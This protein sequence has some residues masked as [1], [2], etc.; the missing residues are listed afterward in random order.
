MLAIRVKQVF[1]GCK[2]AAGAGVVFVDDGR[3][4]GVESTTAD[5]PPGCRV[6][7]R[8]TA[9]VLPG[10]VDA[11]V[12]LLADSGPGALDRL[13]DH[14]DDD[15]DRVIEQTLRVT[16]SSGVTTV[17]DLGDRNYAV[18]EW[19]TQHAR[20]MAPTIVASGPP[21]T[22][23]R[24]HCATCLQDT[25]DTRPAHRSFE[26]T[27]DRTPP[28]VRLRRCDNP[29]SRKGIIMNHKSRISTILA[30][31]GLL[32]T[33]ALGVT[34]GVASAATPGYTYE[35][36]NL[37]SQNCIDVAY[38]SINDGARIQQW[39][40]YHGRPERWR[41]DY[42]ESTY[43][44]YSYLNNGN[45][46]RVD[47]FNVVNDYSGR[48]LDLPYN[49]AYP[50]AQLQQYG[51]WNGPMQQW[52]VVQLGNNRQQIVA[53]VA[54]YLCLDDQDWNRSPGANIQLYWCNG[55]PVQAWTHQPV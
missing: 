55:Q 12:H 45:S 16:L 21:I 48:C 17:R 14:S 47:W 40:C 3:I 34:P 15:C 30:V 35:V 13:A 23:P 53:R 7:D 46:I 43:Y 41:Y 9:I 38:G 1:D 22:T 31:V 50:G 6:L 26:M 24:G 18:L 5:I 29:H 4:V 33:G 8:P 37:N 20:A 36:I 54:P 44:T 49:N 52:G 27:T 28:L 42:I 39:T 25:V 51:C 11:H 32:I 2:V 10:L 19:R